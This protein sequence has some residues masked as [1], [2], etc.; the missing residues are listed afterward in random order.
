V[1]TFTEWAFEEVG[2]QIEW[3]GRGLSEKGCDTA[4]GR[5]LVEVDPRYFRPTEVDLL[6]GDS[7]K[8]RAK[9]G[10]THETSVRELAREMVREDLR[11]M[12]TATIM[13]DA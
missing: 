10:W 4:T 5:T 13:K 6:I 7:S 2:V 9:L 12:K 11:L 8:A 1:R 3:K